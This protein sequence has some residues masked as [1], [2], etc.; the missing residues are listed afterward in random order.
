MEGGEIMDK[1]TWTKKMLHTFCNICIRAIELGMRPI[2][3]FDKIG[4]KFLIKS[5][6]EQTGHSLTIAQLKNKWDGCKKDW[7]IWTKLLFETGVGWS[8]ELGTIA[9]TNEWWTTKIQEVKGAKKFRRAGIEP[10]LKFKYDSMY[11]SI[12]ATGE[13]AWAPSSAVQGGGNSYQPGT[14]NTNIDA[15]DLEEGSGDSKED[16]NPASDNDIAHLVGGG[17]HIK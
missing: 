7:K 4:W 2:T 13:Y 10:A 6:Q 5:F 11:S 8:S 3:H 12:V 14:S 1:A 17:E 15:M 16:G 9:T